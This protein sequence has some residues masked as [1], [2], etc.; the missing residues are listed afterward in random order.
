[1][2]GKKKE[3]PGKTESKIIRH[4]FRLPIEEG[5]NVSLEINDRTYEVINLGTNG[6]GILLDDE[7]SFAA[8]QPLENVMLHL[9]TEHLR[10]KGKVVH[11]SPREFQ[12]ICGIEFVQMTGDEENKMLK[13]LRG[14][15]ES[16][17]GGK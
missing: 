13:F 5:D 2:K 3:Q 9:D 6:I 12:L 16:L 7:D 1:M 4:V 14:H 17:F 8:G 15:R 10:L 11:V